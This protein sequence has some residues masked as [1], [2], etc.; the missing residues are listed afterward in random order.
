MRKILRSNAIFDGENP[1]FKGYVA[2]KGETIEEVQS[3]WDYQHLVDGET[4]VLK[5]DNSFVLPGL[6]DNHVFL[7][8]I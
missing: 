4:T 3:G 2:F 5:Y 6:H 1:P 7:V 8:D